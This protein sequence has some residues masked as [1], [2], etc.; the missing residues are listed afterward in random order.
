MPTARNWLQTLWAAS[1]KGFPFYF[2]RNEIEGGLDIVVHEFPNSDVNFNEDVGESARYYSGTAYVTG[3]TADSQAVNFIAALVSHGPGLLVL[4]TDGPITVRAMRPFKRIVEKDRLGYIAFEVRFVREGAAT[5]LVSVPYLGQLATTAAAA[6]GDAIVAAA[7]AMLTIADQPE[8]VAAA[9]ADEIAAAAAAIDVVRTTYPVDASVSQ[10]VASQLQ[11][12]T[13][14]APLVLDPAGPN[15]SDVAALNSV[16]DEPAPSTPNPTMPV[17]A[18]VL[19]LSRAVV[20]AITTLAGGMQPAVAQDA[21]ASLIDLYAPSAA[22]AQTSI[23]EALSANAATAAANVTNAQQLVRLAALTAWANAL[24]GVT[25]TDRPQG[26]TARAEAA[27]RF[28]IELNN[29]PGAAFH[30]LYLA[31]EALQG[32]VVQFLTQLIANLAPIVT[33]SARASLPSLVWAWKLYQDP[34]RCVDLVLR[35]SVRHPSFMPLSFVALAPGY[36]APGI[37]IAWPAPPL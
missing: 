27:E 5:A 32:S 33:I 10:T 36:A 23:A 14:A 1:Y 30:A 16:M 34:T 8:Y 12:I 29:C 31:I 6:L 3:D 15:T 25:Y 9:A 17:N 22:A 11:A 18:G 4:P 37:P 28:E 20:S 2:E 35:N 19:A 24:L 7:P 13:Q 21:M 26:V